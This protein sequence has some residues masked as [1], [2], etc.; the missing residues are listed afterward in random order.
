[1]IS[2][3]PLPSLW[4]EEWLHMHVKECCGL[5]VYSSSCVRGSNAERLR[6]SLPATDSRVGKESAAFLNN[7]Q[8][9][10]PHFTIQTLPRTNT[11]THTHPWTGLTMLWQPAHLQDTRI[12]IDGGR[13]LKERVS[14][15]QSVKGKLLSSTP[16]L[17]GRND[18][19][20]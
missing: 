5:C 3:I 4:V 13:A 9:S 11:H 19:K 14:P 1:M 16:R 8:T 10:A 2:L 15:K 12:E 6:P 18:T 17:M 20:V 7:N